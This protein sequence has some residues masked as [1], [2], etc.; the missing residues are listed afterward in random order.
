LNKLS[1]FWNYSKHNCFHKQNNQGSTLLTVIM[2]I[3]FIS[4]LG[5]LMLSVTMTNLQ[6][7][8]LESKS[9]KNFYSCEAIMEKIRVAVQEIASDSVKQVYEGDVL[10]NYASYL[11][12]PEADRNEK[13][14]KSVMARFLKTVGGYPDDYDDNELISSEISVKD[15]FFL[16]YLTT[17][18]NG[19]VTWPLMKCEPSGDTWAIRMKDITINYVDPEDDYR[20]SITSDILITMPEF[21]F[22]D[23]DETVDYNM[24]QPF[25]DYVM[26]ADGRITSDN[27][28]GTTS[29]SGNTYAGDGGI[30]MNGHHQVQMDGEIIVTRGDIK[31]SNTASLTIGT[32]TSPVIWADNLVTE[33]SG[34]EPSY[35]TD[36]NINGISVIKDDLVLNGVNSNVNLLSGA[37]IGYTGI[38]TASGSAIMING[39]GSSLNME[40]LSE[41]ILA[42]RAHV[43][44]QDNTLNRDSDILTGESV[45]FK[46]NQRA[47]LIPGE[48]IFDINTNP[49]NHNPITQEDF[50]NPAIGTPSVS[51]PYDA[52][53]QY[54]STPYKIAAKLTGSTTLR[55][56]YYNFADGKS[57]DTFLRQYMAAYP[58]VMDQMEP[59]ALGQVKLPD[60]GA[61][62]AVGNLMSYNT[63]TGV[64]LSDGLS[65][66]PSYADDTALDS[67]IADLTLTNPV[68]PA[69]LQSAK[70]GTLTDMYSQ[71]SH[72]LLID[73]SKAY[74]VDADTVAS[75]ITAGG[76]DYI[77]DSIKNT[78]IV[79][80]G[81]DYNSTESF[82]TDKAFEGDDPIAKTF[83]AVNGNVTIN[84]TFNGYL[85]A[86]GNVIINANFNGFLAAKGD[87]T[88]ADGVK[89]SGMILSTSENGT[90]TVTVGNF[91]EVSGQ[92]ITT[93]DIKLGQECKLSAATIPSD[94]IQTLFDSEEVILSAIFRNPVTV[95]ITM[96]QSTSLVDLSQMI[97]YDNWR[98]TE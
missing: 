4:I 92:L 19:A 64:E 23:G 73:S 47:Y 74:N 59:F 25:A 84:R 62:M 3:A 6:M 66:D 16:T 46:S 93:K 20:S 10:V 9:K 44:V 89:V 13:I 42:G 98:K 7:K 50:T 91:A 79:P 1:D 43:S 27:L 67:Y 76:I 95:N 48:Y 30:Q 49:I 2:C 12:M 36:L 80:Q 11:T 56:Y 51:L 65:S 81:T 78:K 60:T 97:S 15:G 68:Y 94:Q 35:T 85:F 57:A 26:L 29:I 54:A 39:S 83:W 41:L 33:T 55:Y 34:T 88:I 69:L 31:V 72:L 28:A 21:S 18:E 32:T 40:H 75:K 96:T 70:V 90:G 38:H 61:R 37:Y 22:K 8:M 45:A 17:E 52:A 14:Q 86:S 63:T 58:D 82:D 71:L 53:V 77:I 5:S 87:I 24:L